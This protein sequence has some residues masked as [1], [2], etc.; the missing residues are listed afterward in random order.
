MRR[1]HVI[2]FFVLFATGCLFNETSQEDWAVSPPGTESGND[3]APDD[4]PAEKKSSDKDCSAQVGQDWEPEE[5]PFIIYHFLACTRDDSEN[6]IF[7]PA[8]IEISLSEVAED[9]GGPDGQAIA[10]AMGFHSPQK[11]ADHARQYRQNLMERRPTDVRP[12]L[13]TRQIS[14]PDSYLIDEDDPEVLLDALGIE[15]YSVK[16]DGDDE[17]A[18]RW[19]A[20][21]DRWNENFLS[22][23][24][25]PSNV[26]HQLTQGFILRGQWFLPTYFNSPH[27]H[28]FYRNDGTAVAAP[29]FPLLT[30]ASDRRDEK[31]ILQSRFIGEEVGLTAIY[32]TTKT[33]SERES[34]LSNAHLRDWLGSLREHTS[35]TSLYLT[36]P[37]VDLH[38]TVELSQLFGLAIPITS[39]TRIATGEKGVNSPTPVERR[40]TPVDQQ[41]MPLVRKTHPTSR[42]D[43]PF[44]FIIYDYPTE[45]ILMMGRIADPS[46]IK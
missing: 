38:D 4:V 18:C 36:F 3:P 5:F 46:G 35:A 16:C 1:I 2:A 33:L 11:F 12:E 19:S 9:L 25:L 28:K 31:R 45:S 13:S 32:D 30:H 26:V 37:Q 41:H 7:S 40:L 21:N 44:V 17:D 24:H 6:I 39:T 23:E 34:N 22:N 43:E 14:D 8:A 29:F 42:F 10:E 15:F 20:Q 27:S